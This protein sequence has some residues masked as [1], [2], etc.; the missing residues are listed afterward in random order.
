MNKLLLNTQDGAENEDSIIFN[1]RPE[2]NRI[3]YNPIRASIIHLLVKSKD[4]NHTMS[5]EEMSFKLGKRHSVV[6]HH[7][8]K[9]SDWKIVDVVKS[10]K[11]GN[12]ERRSIWGLNLK[13]P[14]L[15]QGIYSHMLKTFYTPT[16]LDKMCCIDKNIRKTLLIV[17]ISFLTFCALHCIAGIETIPCIF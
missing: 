15:V 3:A 5:V 16:K 10:F 11:H 9:L 2:F 7:L 4:L 13:Y 17:G 1:V 14:N 6:I 8:E 12:R